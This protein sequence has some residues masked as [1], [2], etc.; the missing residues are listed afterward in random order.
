[1]HMDGMVYTTAVGGQRV[2]QDEAEGR[3]GRSGGHREAGPQDQ[4]GEAKHRSC[5]GELFALPCLTL[6][7]VFRSRRAGT[8]MLTW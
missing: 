2:R 3:G 4:P 7:F 5:A 8:H 1:M 6:P